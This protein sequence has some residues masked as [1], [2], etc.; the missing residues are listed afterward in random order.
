MWVSWKRETR[1]VLK[2]M[3]ALPLCMSP[4]IWL[5]CLTMTSGIE[6]CGHLSSSTKSS[7]TLLFNP[8]LIYW[9]PRAFPSFAFSL[10]LLFLHVHRR[11][12]SWKAAEKE[13]KNGSFHFFPFNW[14]FAALSVI[15]PPRVGRPAT[16]EH[17]IVFYQE[18]PHLFSHSLNLLPILL[19]FSHILLVHLHSPFSQC[20]SVY[21]CFCS[22]ESLKV[23]QLLGSVSAC[24]A[25]DRV[26]CEE[27]HCRAAAGWVERGRCLQRK[28]QSVRS[29]KR[30]KDGTGNC[31]CEEKKSMKTS[32]GSKHLFFTKFHMWNIPSKKILVWHLFVVFCFC[33]LNISLSFMI[34]I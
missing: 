25:P 12:S 16:E 22:S 6:Y 5:M 15:E 1:L 31:T 30:L 7:R 17:I 21:F 33:Y 24:Q 14:D 8:S 28:Q 9:T 27:R 29:E 20:P 2:V 10:C 3:Y 13:E 23:W 19:H 11:P 34:Y 4:T 32:Q 26:K 18:N